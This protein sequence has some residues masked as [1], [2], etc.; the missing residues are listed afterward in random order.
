MNILEL[1]GRGIFFV[2]DDGTERIGTINLKMDQRVSI[3]YDLSKMDGEIRLTDE[4]VLSELELLE[5]LS[6]GSSGWRL[7]ED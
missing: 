7:I 2:D 6:L 4:Y 1:N 5:R 3:I